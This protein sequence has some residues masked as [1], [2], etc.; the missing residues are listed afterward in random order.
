[1]ENTSSDKISFKEIKELINTLRVLLS[2]LKSLFVRTSSAAKQTFLWGSVAFWLV[3]KLVK[4]IKR[5][6]K[7]KKAK[8]VSE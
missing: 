3:S 2:E 5:R 4:A 6:K 7:A 1:M 8:V